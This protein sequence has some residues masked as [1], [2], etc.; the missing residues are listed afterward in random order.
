MTILPL[1]FVWVQDSSGHLS[2][3]FVLFRKPDM[4][5]NILNRSTGE[6]EAA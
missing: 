2:V 1:A 6:A 4:V 5:V 3:L